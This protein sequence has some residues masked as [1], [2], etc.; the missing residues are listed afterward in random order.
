MSTGNRAAGNGPSGFGAGAVF[1]LLPEL[2]PIALLWTLLSVRKRGTV[3]KALA[4]APWL[5]AF[6]GAA[7][8]TVPA[9]RLGAYEPGAFA[10]VFAA[11]MFVAARSAGR[12]AGGGAGLSGRRFVAGV[13]VAVLL[14]GAWPVIASL[15]GA[16]QLL[17]GWVSHPNLWAAKAVVLAVIV[18]CLTSDARIAVLVVAAGVAGCIATGSRAALVAMMVGT[19]L[20]AVR[21]LVFGDRDDRSRRRTGWASLLMV[22]AIAVAAVI[23]PW[24]QH[25]LDAFTLFGSRGAEA[26]NLVPASEAIGTP[27]WRLVGVQV[28]SRGATGDAAQV[29][30]DKTEPRSDARAVVAVPLEAGREYLATVDLLAFTPGARPGLLGWI[31]P[32]EDVAGTLIAALRGDDVEVTTR[33]PVVAAVE[34]L[35][36]IGGGWKRL[37]VRFRVD[38]EGARSMAFGPSPDLRPATTGAVVGVARLQ[39][40]DAAAP[41]TYFATHQVSDSSTTALGRL[42]I[43]EDAW[44]GFLAAPLLGHGYGS[45]EDHQ[46]A[47][48][49]GRAFVVTHAH[50]LVLQVLYECGIVGLL[51]LMTLLYALTIGDWRPGRFDTAVLIG[52]VLAVNAFDL[53]FWSADVLL[54]LVTFAG[55]RSAVDISQLGAGGEAR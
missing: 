54:P 5:T 38:G 28:A 23:G 47:A 18:L 27:P 20:V 7:L 30:L 24:R 10:P 29:T 55:W 48:R 50:D 26:Y 25:V 36:D 41:L 9:V 11:A 31:A 44:A 45:F 35:Q 40:A 21:L 52:T 15:S 1:G 46:A 17:A 14:V 33:G 22:V 6:V 3:R 2:L 43:F 4:A 37:R 19:L 12:L 53:S 49:A 13:A 8:L 32:G 51:G 34:D 16:D 39:V 42:T